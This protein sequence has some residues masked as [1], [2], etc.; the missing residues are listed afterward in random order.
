MERKA[1]VEQMPCSIR[2]H[3][4]RL[5]AKRGLKMKIQQ[6]I[7]ALNTYNQAVSKLKDDRAKLNKYK[8]Y[9]GDYEDEDTLK[10]KKQIEIDKKELE[11]VLDMEV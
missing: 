8:V 3:L 4:H 7:F 9:Y 10:L 11:R 6:I 2:R 5:C 1:E